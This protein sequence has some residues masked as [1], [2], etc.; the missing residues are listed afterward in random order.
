MTFSPLKALPGQDKLVRDGQGRPCSAAVR[1][2]PT[3]LLLPEAQPQGLPS[4]P[5]GQAPAHSS[6][7]P[8]WS[9]R[10]GQ[11]ALA[12]PAQ[13]SGAATCLFQAALLNYPP[14]LQMRL[15]SPYLPRIAPRGT[16]KVRDPAREAAPPTS[17]LPASRLLIAPPKKLVSLHFSNRGLRLE[18]QGPDWGHAA[19]GWEPRVCWPMTSGPGLDVTQRCGQ[20][21]QDPRGWVVALLGVLGA[22]GLHAPV[23]RALWLRS[24]TAGRQPRAGLASPTPARTRADG[25]APGAGTTWLGTRRAPACCPPQLGRRAFGLFA[26]NDL[27]SVVTGSPT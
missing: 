26:N 6:W 24:G 18:G 27:F 21:Q 2:G 14:L 11:S 20:S 3:Q 19:S 16:C 5:A 7:A 12:T 8:S 10:T 1:A 25:G 9:L 23:S 17:L 4:G 13:H 22:Q 15:L